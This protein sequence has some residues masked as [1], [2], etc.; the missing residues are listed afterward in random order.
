MKLSNI[1]KIIILILFI[2]FLFNNISLSEKSIE[3]KKIYTSYGDTLWSI[4]K[5]QKENN[6]YYKDKS[7]QYIINDI[8]DINKLKNSSLS[9][10]QELL[11]PELK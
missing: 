9:T 6:V 2:I 5:E 3:Y 11:I 10:G 4:A 1:L 8:K 7:L